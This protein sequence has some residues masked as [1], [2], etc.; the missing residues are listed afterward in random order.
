MDERQS[1]LEAEY[2]KPIL[3]AEQRHAREMASICAALR[4]GI[5]LSVEE[6]RQGRVRRT[7]LEARRAEHEKELAEFRKPFQSG[8]DWM[9]R[10]GNGHQPSS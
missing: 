1:E 2:T 6:Q 8:L 4:R 3:A 10:G 5:R 7:E 9:C